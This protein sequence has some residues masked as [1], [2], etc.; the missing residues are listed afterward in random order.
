MNSMFTSW[1]ISQNQMR[2][3]VL[4]SVLVRIAAPAH[5]A[6]VEALVVRTAPV[7]KAAVRLWWKTRDERVTSILRLASF[8]V[9]TAL[10]HS[11]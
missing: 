3:V 6:S 1:L 9:G 11:W 4:V 10:H 2:T 8:V 5:V 7:A